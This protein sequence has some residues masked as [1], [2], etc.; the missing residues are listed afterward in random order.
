LLPALP[1]QPAILI[2]VDG[3][4][5]DARAVMVEITRQRFD[6]LLEDFRKLTIQEL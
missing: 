4:A 2:L 5:I 3:R 1:S 6:S